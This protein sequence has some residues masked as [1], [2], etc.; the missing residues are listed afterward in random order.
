MGSCDSSRSLGR[1]ESAR[2]IP[3]SGRSSAVSMTPRLPSLPSATTQRPG[4]D[5]LRVITRMRPTRHECDGT[6]ADVCVRTRGAQQVVVTVPGTSV[7]AAPTERGFSFDLALGPDCTQEELYTAVGQP[8]LAD[9]LQGYN[10]CLFAYGQT[11]SGKT[12]SLTGTQHDLGITGRL[13]KEMFARFV[14]MLEDEACQS[15]DVMLTYYEVYNETVY[16]LLQP[17]RLGPDLRPLEVRQD[18]EHRAAVAGLSQHAALNAE[19]VSRLLRIGNRNRHVS[20]TRMNKASS[21]SHALLQLHI[22]QTLEKTAALERDLESCLT[23]VDLAGS[24]RAGGEAG[25]RVEESVQINRSLFVLGRALRALA[26]G[27]PHVPMR[28]SKLTRLLGDYFGG[29]SRTVMLATV[30]PVATHASET[31]STLEFAQHT[32]SVRQCARVNRRERVVDSAAL[33]RQVDEAQEL[34]ERQ[35]AE[36]EQ[37]L[38]AKDVRI[39]Q[40]EGQSHHGGVGPAADLLR[41]NA[42]HS[43]S[44]KLLDVAMDPEE[45]PTESP[46]AVMEAQRLEIEHLKALMEYRA[47]CHAEIYHRFTDVTASYRAARAELTASQERTALQRRA[48]C[49]AWDHARRSLADTIAT[50]EQTVAALWDHTRHLGHAAAQ[51]GASSDPRLLR[52][53]VAALSG[54]GAALEAALGAQRRLAGDM[55]ATLTQATEGVGAFL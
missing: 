15:I 12:H 38:M 42:W 27:Q 37:Q 36:F 23:I 5:N 26:D 46:S 20:N 10:G 9:V 48:Y 29:N 35:K 30:A 3:G 44:Q 14:D 7:R 24:E 34:L 41:S 2:S 52:D 4:R 6:D 53:H 11:G 47:Q 25:A 21:R 13:C 16:D 39:R 31:L 17:K 8:L 40:L 55:A 28:D 1:C 43:Y 51:P 45:G 18:G 49:G 32:A 54:T 19:A 22:R 50:Q 33:Q